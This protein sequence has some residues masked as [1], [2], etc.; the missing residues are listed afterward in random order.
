MKTL[1]RDH[2]HICVS[3]R[4]MSVLGVLTGNVACT[5]HVLLSV[6]G[7]QNEDTDPGPATGERHSQLL[8]QAGP[9]ASWTPAH[10]SISSSTSQGASRVSHHGGDV[11]AEAD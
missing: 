2:A 10:R 7:L 4:A 6:S 5:H 11:M 3:S 1:G 8:S 9:S